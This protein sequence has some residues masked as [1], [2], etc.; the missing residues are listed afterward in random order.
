MRL[1]YL[2]NCTIPSGQ[3]FWRPK[4]VMVP[5]R[6]RF[7]AADS[8]R[9]PGRTVY[10][11][12]LIT[13]GPLFRQL[14]TL[15]KGQH[16]LLLVY[17]CTIHVAFAAYCDTVDR[18]EVE[19]EREALV[20]STARC[21]PCCVKAPAQHC[22]EAILICVES[23]AHIQ[24]SSLDARKGGCMYNSA[25]ASRSPTYSVVGGCFI[26]FYLSSISAPWLM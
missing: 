21:S 10:T 23:Q 12:L 16:Q 25:L 13:L 9:V 24:S 11:Y 1:E 14:L 4:C 3:K 20:P 5:D 22:T 17:L 2:G 19:G 8:K 6:L 18:R 7:N 15:H 26:A